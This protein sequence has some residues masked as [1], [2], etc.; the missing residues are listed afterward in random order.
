MSGTKEQ[1]Q[2]LE[3]SLEIDRF[4]FKIVDDLKNVFLVQ[5]NEYIFVLLLSRINREFL[6][7]KRPNS[8]ID[9]FTLILILNIVYFKE[10]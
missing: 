1:Q 5:I 3:I 4:I 6:N 2:K 7:E 9:V 10:L 8:A